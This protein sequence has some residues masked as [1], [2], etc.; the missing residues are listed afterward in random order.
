ME[1]DFGEKEA[2]QG[3]HEGQ[4][5]M[6]HEAR[7]PSRVGPARSPLVALILSIFVSMNLS[8]PKTDYIKG[9]PAGREEERRQNIETRNRSLGDQR[10]EGK[11]LAGCCRWDLHPLRWLYLCHHDEEGVVHLWTTGLWQ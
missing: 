9:A 3:I 4:T 1:Q 2:Q 11:T 7:F 10:L 6:A 5:S 8:W